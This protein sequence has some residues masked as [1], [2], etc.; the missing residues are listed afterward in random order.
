MTAGVTATGELVGEF[1]GRGRIHWCYCL[2]GSSH[3]MFNLLGEM[4][5]LF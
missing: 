1:H 4:V 5:H 3:G 2:L